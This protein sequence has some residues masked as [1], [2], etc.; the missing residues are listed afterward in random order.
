MP[1]PVLQ[2]QEFPRPEAPRGI[3]SRSRNLA[4]DAV[5]KDRLPTP[6]GRQ[7]EVLYLPANGHTVVLGTAG[8]GKTTL[9]V[10]R[11]LYLRDPRTDHAG[12]TLLVTFNRCLVSYL[13][14]LAGFPAAID[15]RNYHHFARGYLASR[16]YSL[17]WRICDGDRRRNLVTRAVADVRQQHGSSAVLRR[18]VEFVAEEFRWLAQHG[19]SSLEEYVDSERVGRAGTRVTRTDRPALYKAYEKYKTLRSAVG[20]DFDWDDLSHAVLMELQ[21]DGTGRLYR[22]IVVDEGQDFSP[23]MLKSLAAAIPEDGSLTFFGDM[24][25]QIYGNRMSWRGA[26]LNVQRDRIWRFEENY[27]NSRQ[28]ARLAL[29]I[30]SMPQ[31]PGDPDLVEPKS[32]RADGPLPALVRFTSEV[33]A[34]RFAAAQARTAAATQQVAVLFRDRQAET[35]LVR[36]LGQTVAT[37]LHRDLRVWPDGPGLFYGTYH[38]AKGL[39][40]DTVLLPF[41]S[42]DHLPHPPDVASFGEADAA[43]QDSKLLYVG[44]TRAKSNLILTYAGDQTRLLPSDDELYARSRR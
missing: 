2:R 40:F 22:H 38:S 44:V 31:F 23:M 29:A 13:R 1:R 37:R 39:E 12:R 5:M 11:S 30:A 4:V 34:T 36:E 25:Q 18:P 6:V 42:S 20:K 24:A 32:P 27:R 28:I 16:G 8:S 9:A 21:R 7:K 33:E 17:G 35:A 26:G 10:L 43:T 19:I 15:V 14:S 41:L 3:E